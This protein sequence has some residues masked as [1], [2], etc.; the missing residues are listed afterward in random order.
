[1]AS[2][3]RWSK[4]EDEI[5][6]EYVGFHSPEDISLILKKQGF[7]RTPEA[8]RSRFKVLKISYAREF[9]DL[10]LSR[11]GKLLGV[12]RST[13]S[14][15]HRTGKIKGKPLGKGREIVVKYEEVRNFLKKYSQKL[16]T[17]L[18][19]DGLNFFLGGE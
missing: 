11:I 16:K 3:V 18:D 5:L 13:T 19:K 2:W 9:D 1:M 10:S 12:S 17:V 6:E 8:V 14:S 7:N 4:K 15:W